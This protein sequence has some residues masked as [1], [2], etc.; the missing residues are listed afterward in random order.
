MKVVTLD[1]ARDQLGV[2]CEDA[3]NGETVLLQHGADTFVLQPASS[4]AA[5]AE[6]DWDDSELEAALLAA[7]EGAHT[8]LADGELGARG[9][10]ILRQLRDRR[11]S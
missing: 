5:A 3:Q 2:L 9:R 4:G 10:T 1:Q 7:V 11:A 8:P 6:L